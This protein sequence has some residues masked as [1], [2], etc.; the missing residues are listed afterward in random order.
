MLN[1]SVIIVLSLILISKNFILL[2]EETLILCCFIVFCWLSFN[3]LKELIHFDFETQREEIETNVSDS[4]KARV[5]SLDV[6]LKWQKLFP[7]LITNFKIL[8]KQF[9]NLSIQ[10]SA[11]LPLIRNREIQKAYLKKLFFTKRLEQ[12][13][14][15]LI[16][17]ILIK[18]IEKIT[19]LK[20]FYSTKIKITT[21]QCN[22][23]IIL[24]EYIEAI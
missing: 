15:K 2:N 9:I 14:S 19:F 10:I 7:V 16:S 11:Q 21:F 1:L 8:E 5:A 4:F 22:Y 13:T 24:R 3:K 17:L 23:K 6:N 18:K 12:Q 20:Y